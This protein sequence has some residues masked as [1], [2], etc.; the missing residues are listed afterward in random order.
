MSASLTF[1]TGRAGAGKSRYLRWAIKEKCA[2]NEDCALIVPEQFTF[3]AEREL[4]EKLPGGLMNAEVYSFSSLSTRVLENAGVHTVFLS[5]QGRRMLIRRAA[6]ECKGGLLAFGG[7]CERPGFAASC[8]DMFS[9]YKRCE[10]SPEEVMQTALAL[11]EDLLGRKMRDLALLYKK[12][13]E[14]IAGRGIRTE[15][16]LSAV[17]EHIKSSFICGKH[18]FVDNCDFWAEQIYGI[19]GEIMGCAASLTVCVRGDLN[20]QGRD[21]RLFA[22]EYKA[23]ERVLEMAGKK[24]CAISYVSLPQRGVEW[25]GERYSNPAL[26]HLEHELFANPFEIYQHEAKGI[27]LFAATD[28]VSEAEAAAQA[29]QRA[30]REGLRYREMALVACGLPA[31]AQSVQRTLRKRGIPYFTDAKHPLAR[32]PLARLLSGA[33]KAVTGGYRARDMIEICKTGLAGVERA[34]TEIFENYVLRFGIRGGAFNAPFERGEV[35]AEAEKARQT[36]MAPLSLLQAAL[37]RGQSAREKTEALYDYIDALDVRS[38]AQAKNEELREG[39]RHALMEENRQ[40]Y[41]ALMELFSQLHALMGDARL[42]NAHFLSVFEE[43][44]SAYDIGA[45]PATADQLLFGSIDRTRARSIKAL[46]LLGA[47]E[48]A[49]PMSTQDDGLIDDEELERLA[50]F[51][52]KTWDDSASHAATARMDAYM[53]LT[54]PGELLYVSCETASEE[55]PSALIERI[56][57]LFP[58]LK[59]ESGISGFADLAD[60]EGGFMRLCGELRDYSDGAEAPDE[61]LYAWYMK[62]EAYSERLKRVEKAAFPSDETRPIGKEAALALYGNSGSASRLECFN[63]CGF[64]HYAR[65]GLKL[66]PRREYGER[67]TDEGSFCHEALSLFVNALLREKTPLEQ[68]TREDVSRLLSEILPP[69]LDTHNGGIFGD[70]ARLRAQGRRLASRVE[71]TAWAVTRQLAAG[72]FRPLG[73]ELSFGKNGKLPGLRFSVEGRD[74]ILS[75][76]IDRLDGFV[77]GAEK[78]Y[79]VVDYKSGGEDFDFADVYYGLRLQLPLYIAAA[80]ELDKAIAAGIYYMPVDDP[81][82]DEELPLENELIKH[83][84]MKGITLSEPLIEE[85]SDSEGLGVLQPRS[86]RVERGSMRRLI[87]YSQKKSRE[88]ARRISEGEIAAHPVMKRKTKRAACEYCDYKSLCRFDRRIR[89]FEYQ[90]VGAMDKESFMEMSNDEVDTAAE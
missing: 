74:Y 55:A 6:E 21:R 66:E 58:N 20:E 25:E 27:R 17:K 59:I 47:S 84:R 82:V 75:G 34:D 4:S 11:P 67:R 87:A 30:A 83:F 33:L 5:A 86:G 63:T 26:S 2:L 49:L 31:Y 36:L 35:P 64:K 32:Y 12:S 41:D 22:G 81:A 10:L 23:Y 89:G 1:V 71:A 9:L 44:L 16:A 73:T 62:N 7:V 45:I 37:K 88:T 68:M 28:K 79:R 38:A 48:G 78:Y 76:K 85:A 72:S 70:G 42:S 43:G 50:A 29:I 60:A 14:M 65:Y 52:M 61:E 77:S 19:L 8:D 39:G 57:N 15:D 69:L 3:E 46:F 13:E 90:S 54:K 24:E 56:L 18:I 40:V 80:T 51:G 53:A